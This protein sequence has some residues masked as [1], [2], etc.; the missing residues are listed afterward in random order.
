MRE[1][2]TLRDAWMRALPTLFASTPQASLRLSVR[3]AGLGNDDS[4]TDRPRASR[5]TCLRENITLPDLKVDINKHRRS[6]CKVIRIQH[7][8]QV[9]HELLPQQGSYE[10]ATTNQTSYSLAPTKEY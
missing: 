8:H 5:L 10:L 7:C 2:G 4:R 3:V 9:L 6:L 1:H